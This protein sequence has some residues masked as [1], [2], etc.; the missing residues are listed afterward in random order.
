MLFIKKPVFRPGFVQ[1]LGKSLTALKASRILRQQPF[2]LEQ[3][4]AAAGAAADLEKG[5]IKLISKWRSA[6][7]K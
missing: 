6:L 7:A 1:V 2:L 4:T 3:A 5:A